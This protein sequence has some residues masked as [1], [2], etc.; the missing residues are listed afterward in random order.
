MHRLREQQVLHQRVRPA[1]RASSGGASARSRSPASPAAT[2]GATCRISIARAAETWITGSYDP[3]L[4]LTYWGTTQAK[5][6]M[7]ASR[8]MKG[9]RRRALLELHARARR[10]HRQARV[11]LLARAGRSVRSR[12]RVRA[13]AD[14]RPGHDKWVLSVGKDGVLWKHDRKTGAYLDHVETVFQNVWASFDRETGTPRYRPDILDA[15]VGE[16]VDA[17]PST[18]GGKNWHAMS[19]HRPSRQADHSAVAELHVA[20][21]AGRSSRSR[22]AAAAAART[23]ATTRCRARTATSASSARSTWTRSKRRGR[24]QQRASFLTGVLSTAGGV[25]FV[26]DLD[27]SFKAVDVRDGKVLWRD[28]ARDVRAGLPDQRSRSDGRQYVAVATGLGGGSPRG[29]PSIDHA[30]DPAAEPRARAVRVR[31]AALTRRATSRAQA[32][33]RASRPSRRRSCRRCRAATRNRPCRQRRRAAP[34]PAN[35]P[36]ASRPRAALR[37]R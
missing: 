16:W 34:G 20:A 9:T 2:A 4:N 7:P 33:P 14:R 12:R 35:C 24:L 37:V 22:A 29:V 23:A 8:G 6:W 25:A 19:F 30:G 5:P 26:G 32:S 28:A 17:C 36:R 21:R 31:V 3:D 13:R 27:R 15:K 18:A 10:E 11:A 1:R